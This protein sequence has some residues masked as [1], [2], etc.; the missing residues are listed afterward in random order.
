MRVI[1]IALG[2]ALGAGGA[3]KPVAIKDVPPAVRRTIE[4]ERRGA[5]VQA[6]SKERVRGH[7]RYALET[8][9]DGHGRNIVID[10]YGRVIEV[11]EEMPVEEL[12]SAVRKRFESHGTITK[13]E[14]ITRGSE[15]SYEATLDRRGRKAH[16]AVDPGGRVLR[17]S[18]VKS[19]PS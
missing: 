3:A 18:R 5:T 7:T 17:V 9:I 6:L 19:R 4:R 2:L 13:A 10:E 16:M 1:L 14:Q 8:L 12:P 11:G 15:R